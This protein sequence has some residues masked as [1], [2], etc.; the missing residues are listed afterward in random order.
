MF[1]RANSQHQRNYKKY[2]NSYERLISHNS[3]HFDVILYLMEFAWS[4]GELC[5]AIVQEPLEAVL[6]GKDQP[7]IYYNS[8]LSN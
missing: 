3:L 1:L 4:T 5:K 7:Y 2:H 8:K 6:V